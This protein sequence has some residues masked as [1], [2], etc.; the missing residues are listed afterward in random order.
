MDFR[1]NNIK[2]QYAKQCSV[3]WPNSEHCTEIMYAVPIAINS[4]KYELSA[5]SLGKMW[6]ELGRKHLEDHTTWNEYQKPNNNYNMLLWLGLSLI[7]LLAFLA[8]LFFMKV[9]S[10]R[11]ST[12]L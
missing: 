4:T 2:I 6:T 8:F 11:L 5:K 7:I 3:Q 1:P 12:Q 10:L 9:F